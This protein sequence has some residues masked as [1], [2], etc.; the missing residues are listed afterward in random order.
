MS[1]I[2]DLLGQVLTKVNASDDVMTFVT[3]SGDVYTMEHYQDCC[4]S[5]Y[6]ESIVGDLE[7]LIGEPILTAEEVSDMPSDFDQENTDESY[8]WTF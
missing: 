4:E 7:D 6:I 8:T 2:A 5:V 1:G 3:T